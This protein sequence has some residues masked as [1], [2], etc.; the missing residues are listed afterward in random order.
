MEG[1][2]IREGGVVFAAGTI[3]D[4]GK[5]RS[6]H[7]RHPDA[8]VIDHPGCTILP[9]LV[10]AHVHLELS[11]LPPKP[12]PR[13]FIDW[14][15]DLV[16][17]GPLDEQAARQSVTRS[18]TIGVEQCLRFGV[19]CVGDVTAHCSLTRS[20]LAG[21]PLRVVSY[22]EV[23]A[24]AQ[25]RRLLEERIADAIDTTNASD[26]LRIG[27]SPH[28]PY[29]VEPH[30][31][32]RCLAEART[33]GLP[34]ATHLAE[35]DDEAPFL[36]DHAGPL[37]ELWDRLGAWDHDVPTFSGGPIRFA[38]SI[39]LLD[40]PTAL[41]HV[42]HCDNAEMDLLAAAKASVVYCPR[43]HA[44]FGH[45]PHRWREMLARGINVAVG[46]DSCASSPDLN[47]VD[48]LR[49]LRRLAP[50]LPADR[51]WE[52]ATVRSARAIRMDRLVGT[53]TRGKAADF[54]LFLAAG[55]D[56][57]AEILDEGKLPAALWIG[58]TPAG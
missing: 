53:L 54:V 15:W 5:A 41:A 10:N 13:R 24:M 52:M 55:N 8:I 29:S 31:Y 7:T 16:P 3:L 44:F 19:T 2:A 57:L 30:G 34:L 43:T 9:G 4:V 35:T 32:R 23:R 28:A 20:F 26:R 38:H 33:R 58:G 25:R 17:T 11:G 46:T 27:V 18:L 50:D 1:P 40:Y 39:G 36:A 47:L 45:P 14:L 42:N 49:V 6:L 12:R 51:L 37:R 56:P 22:G 21:G 48:D